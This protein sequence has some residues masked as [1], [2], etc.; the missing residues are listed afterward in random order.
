MRK[1][2][3]VSKLV[4][5]T[6]IHKVHGNENCLKVSMVHHKIKLK[7]FLAINRQMK[8]NAKN[9]LDDVSCHSFKID[10]CFRFNYFYTWLNICMPTST[11]TLYICYVNMFSRHICVL[12]TKSNERKE[13]DIFTETFDAMR[14]AMSIKCV[15]ELQFISKTCTYRTSIL[16]LLTIEVVRANCITGVNMVI[17]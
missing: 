11:I 12:P 15:L 10:R 8:Y 4:F 9:G 6:Q 14:H 16:L 3:L 7:F 13:H 2:C 1:F 17:H 5:L